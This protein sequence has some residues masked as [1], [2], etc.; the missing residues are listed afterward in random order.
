MPLA[1]GTIASCEV[2]IDGAV[3]S[4]EQNDHM[5]RVV[6]ERSWS[7]VDRAELEFR[8]NGLESQFAVGKALEVKMT[9][10]GGSESVKVFSGKIVGV[11]LRL[12]TKGS[13]YVT[14]EALDAR[15]A[16][17]HKIEPKTYENVKL[18]DIVQQIASAHGLT[19]QGD[20][21]STVYDHFIVADSHF[22]VLQYIG[23][24]TGTVWTLDDK[25]L[26]FTDPTKQEGGETTL[27]YGIDLLDLDLRYA[28][29]EQAGEVLVNGWDQSQGKAIVGKSAAS[30]ALHQTGLI[31][32]SKTQPTKAVAWGG[33]AIDAKEAD[34]LA[35]GISR[36]LRAGDLI[37]A[38][39]A[40]LTPALVPGGRV[41]L[42]NIGEQFSGKHVLSSVTHRFGDLDE[43]GSTEFR[44]GPDDA[45]LDQMLGDGGRVGGRAP[46][47]ITI[48][49]VTDT[50]DPKNL[51]RIRVKLPLISDQLQTGWVRTSSLGTGK[52]RGIVFVPEINDEVV[53]AFEHGELNRPYVLGGLWNDVGTAFEGA[54]KNN[55]T[56]ERR[57]VSKLGSAI[58][59][60]DVQSGDDK[61]G[62]AIE[63]DGAKT[64]IFMGYKQVTIETQGRPLEIKNGSAS[65][66]MD[67]NDITITA[68]NI[69]IDAKQK[70]DVKSG[71]DTNVK[72]GANAKV[73][74]SA[75]LNLKGGAMTTVESSGIT[76]VKG[77][78]VQ[79][80]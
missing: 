59:F 67:Q 15:H 8:D 65:I 50:K 79:V 41:E 70:L 35:T 69:T 39:R 51:G 43:A 63:M 22:A 28:P 52:D 74:A 1:T 64:R 60:V 26:T 80:N 61:S 5:R 54:A 46:N 47:G 72:A 78:M 45:S 10:A 38:G 3:L 76:A 23:R 66:K 42:K 37:G 33:G 73:E 32:S 20:L 21:G 4:K 58:R 29:V 13:A 68:N 49:I 6:V 57:M 62:I 53:V 48:G 2:T 71:L 55:Q 7:A 31:G 25:K 18:G 27:E 77:S 30:K 56:D 17:M 12:L 36:R 19:Y 34:T 9:A 11:G 75:Q 40:L 24:R 14:V 44:V 16:L